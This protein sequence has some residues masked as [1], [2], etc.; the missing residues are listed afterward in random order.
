MA[1]TTARNVFRNLRMMLYWPVTYIYLEIQKQSY[2]RGQGR[3]TRQEL[4]ISAEGLYSRENLAYIDK[5]GSNIL[6][7]AG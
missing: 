2:P 4:I 3:S 6:E 5:H 1:E 7:R